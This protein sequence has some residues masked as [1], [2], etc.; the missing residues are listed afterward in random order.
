[1]NKLR[2]T[3]F[4]LSFMEQ[5]ILDFGEIIGGCVLIVLPI[6][7]IGY[8]MQIAHKKQQG[9]LFSIIEGI[10]L[11]CIVAICAFISYSTY[12]QLSWMKHTHLLLFLLSISV[13]I[14]VVYNWMLGSK[15]N[16]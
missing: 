15:F 4:I 7:I 2:I 9:K 6:M 1:M 16:K 5:R 13:V 12:L 3:L 8:I 11:I 14:F 10:N